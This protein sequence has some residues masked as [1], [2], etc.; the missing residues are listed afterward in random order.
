MHEQLRPFLIGHPTVEDGKALGWHLEY[1]PWEMVEDTETA[2]AGW[3][4]EFVSDAHAVVLTMLSSGPT[5]T[6][7]DDGFIALAA[8]VGLTPEELVQQFIHTRLVAQSG[9]KLELITEGLVVA[10]LPDGQFVAAEDNTG[11]LSQWLSANA[12]NHCL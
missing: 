6:S 7:D 11:R 10:C 4:P 1:L 12:A 9:N 8:D 2:Y 5:V 3:A